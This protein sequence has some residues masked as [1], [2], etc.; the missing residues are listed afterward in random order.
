MEIEKTLNKEQQKAIRHDAGPLLIVAGAGTGKTTVITQRI[1]WL[2]D[3]KKASP[4]EILALTFTEKAAGEMEERVDRLLPYGYVDLWISTFHSFAERILRAHALDIGLPNNSRLLDTTA[5]WMLVH[6]HLDAF[7]LEYYKP[8]GNPTKFIHALLTHFSRLKDENIMPEEYLAYAESL[9]GDTDNAEYVERRKKS[10]N[11]KHSVQKNK[12]PIIE[13]AIV[14][15]DDPARVM[16]VAC[17]YHTYQRLLAEESAMDFGD[18]ISNTLTLFK[19]RPAILERYRRQFRYLLVDEFQD[20]N[21]AQYE[22]VKLL[23]APKNNLTVVA[24]DDQSI[25]RFRGASMSNIVAFTKDYAGVTSV[26]LTTNYRSRQNILDYAYRF[27]QLNNPNRLEWHMAKDSKF[28]A[29][30][31]KQIARKTKTKKIQSG[32]GARQKNDN[33][34]PTTHSRQPNQEIDEAVKGLGNISKKLIASEKGRGM[35]EHIHAAT[36]DDEVRL[37]VEKILELRDTNSDTSWNDYAILVRANATATP[38]LTALERMGISYQFVASKGLYA[39]PIVLDILAYIRLLDDYH[40]SAAVYRVLANPLFGVDDADI[41]KLT[42]HARK[43]AISLFAVLEQ[44]ASIYGVSEK[45]Y[46]AIAKFRQLVQK[47]TAL[48]RT[49]SVTHVVIAFLEDSGYLQS[50]SAKDS[51]ENQEMISALNQFYK[52]MQA[53]EN[54]E[55]DK[56]SRN[57]LAFVE[58]ERQAGEE[59]SLASVA[60]EGPEAVRVLTVHA[61]KGLESRYVFVVNMVDKRFPTL[62]RKD[63]IEVPQSLVKEIVPEGDAHLE[64]ERRLFYVAMTRAREGL[65]FTSADDYGGVRKKKLSRFMHEI[66]FGVAE[67]KENKEMVR[68]AGNAYMRLLQKGARIET[69]DFASL[70]PP[71]RFSFTQLKAYEN[72]PWQYRFAH[73]LKIPLRGKAVFSYGQ[74]MHGTLQHIYAL[75]QKR[76]AQQEKAPTLFDAQKKKEAV[77]KNTLGSLVAKQEVLDFFEEK[78]IDDWYESA[79][80]KKK[81]F[82]QGKEALA[83]WYEKEKD[84]LFATLFIEK[85]FSMKVAVGAEYFTVSG[86]IDRVDA[87]DGKLRI[88]DYKTGIAKEELAPDD[89]DQLLIYQMA[90]SEI[91][92]DPIEELTFYYLDKQKQISFIGS[93]KDLERQREKMSRTIAQIRTMRFPPKPGRMCKFCDFR[94]I[95]EFRAS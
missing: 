12:E 70:Q 69:Q 37:V 73:I 83:G 82:Q 42:V 2:I 43:K 38:F 51:K 17:A 28:E 45:T 49:G 10:K 29:Q 78:W 86:K 35:I 55:D 7:A 22:L 93:D 60:D 54:E 67:E 79:E 75:A 59:G 85:G 66:G 36:L 34:L 25:Y 18:L 44:S 32:D 92:D 31:A 91:F 89:K 24:D 3:E 16:E 87:V 30:N 95:C 71:H 76:M 74:S 52:R 20:T 4:D 6:K 81:Y 68:A 19:K 13:S 33:P 11:K 39:R 64:E 65:F 72:C 84:A 80:Q 48:A 62:E 61:A 5:Q 21:M 56:T 14:P 77:K 46:A 58:L 9:Q 57:F 41:I 26:F 53:F 1:A 8:L 90:A 94:E 27:I 63:S 88:I 47:H 40:E 50:I 15:E 23:A